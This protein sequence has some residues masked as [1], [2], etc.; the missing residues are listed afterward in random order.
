MTLLKLYSFVNI[1]LFFAKLPKE[2]KTLRVFR[3]QVKLVVV[4]HLHYTQL[5]CLVR[6]ASPNKYS[7]YRSLPHYGR[8]TLVFLFNF[9]LL[10]C[11][12][13][14]HCTTLHYTEGCTLHCRMC[15]FKT[16][17][18]LQKMFSD[19]CVLPY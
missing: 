18:R 15:N 5:H 8:V 17:L 14:L 12:A 19:I 11:S 16:Y 13:L 3:P 6:W 4:L 9:T 1:F 10:H 2:H 7:N